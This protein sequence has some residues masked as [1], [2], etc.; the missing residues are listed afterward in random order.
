MS[1]WQTNLS[2]TFFIEI[3]WS[4]LMGQRLTSVHDVSFTLLICRMVHWRCHCRGG[5]GYCWF[6]AT[7]E[8]GSVKLSLVKWRWLSCGPQ[9][10]DSHAN[11]HNEIVQNCA[12]CLH[13]DVVGTSRFRRFR[14]LYRAVVQGVDQLMFRQKQEDFAPGTSPRGEE[15]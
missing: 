9:F 2:A 10:A 15:I 3:F 4:T 14:Y 1:C 13:S 8:K 11:N 6:I 7:A 5:G 12:Y